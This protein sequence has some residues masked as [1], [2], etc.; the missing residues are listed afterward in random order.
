MFINLTFFAPDLAGK[1]LAL[2]L[3]LKAH[4]SNK[5]SSYHDVRF[6]FVFLSS[7]IQVLGIV[8]QA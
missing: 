1:W 8:R 4:G 2:L 3:M 5:E 6:F 7:F